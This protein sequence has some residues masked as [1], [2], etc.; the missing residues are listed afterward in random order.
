VERLERVV[1]RRVQRQRERPS[2]FR[3]RDPQ[4]AVLEIDLIPAQVEEAAATKSRVCRQNDR[5]AEKPISSIVSEW[6][7]WRI[8]FLPA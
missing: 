3:P 4:H 6:R 5:V 1:R 2:A 7:R 8:W